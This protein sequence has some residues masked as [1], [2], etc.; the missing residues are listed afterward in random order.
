MVF[1]I[2]GTDEAG[3][4]ATGQYGSQDASRDEFPDLRGAGP[5]PVLMN[6]GKLEAASSRL[7]PHRWPAPFVPGEDFVYHSLCVGKSMKGR[8]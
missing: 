7:C 3:H 4:A 8:A 6:A 5:R 2:C 1:A